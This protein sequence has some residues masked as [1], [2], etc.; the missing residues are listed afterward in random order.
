[1]L[2]EKEIIDRITDKEIKRLSIEWEIINKIRDQQHNKRLTIIRD[3][4]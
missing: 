1:L 2:T 4:Q 3:Y